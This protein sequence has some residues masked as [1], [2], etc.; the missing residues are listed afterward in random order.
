MHAHFLETSS[1]CGID[2]IVLGSINYHTVTSYTEHCSFINLKKKTTDQFFSRSNGHTVNTLLTLLT[3]PAWLECHFPYTIVATISICNIKWNILC[4]FNNDLTLCFWLSAV[5]EIM[6]VYNF[7][8]N[9]QN[10]NDLIEQIFNFYSVSYSC[11][12]TV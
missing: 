4:W 6:K 11:S 8:R 2:I 1:S 3:L 10:L 12:C 9:K 5:V 7:Q